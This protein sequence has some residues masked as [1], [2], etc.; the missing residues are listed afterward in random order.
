MGASMRA[1]YT[2][3]HVSALKSVLF[4][5]ITAATNAMVATRLVHTFVLATMR[6]VLA[7]VYI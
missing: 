2:F 3:V 6:I 1:S 5:F 4:E 7:L